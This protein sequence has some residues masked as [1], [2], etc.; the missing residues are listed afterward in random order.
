MS[1][2]KINVKGIA[3]SGIKMPQIKIKFGKL[4]QLQLPVVKSVLMPAYSIAKAP[5]EPLKEPPKF[6]KLAKMANIVVSKFF[7]HIFAI[8]TTEGMYAIMPTM[9]SKTASPN[10]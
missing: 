8:R 3:R 10:I 7:G 9:D 4:S 2:T 5:K 6:A 1:G